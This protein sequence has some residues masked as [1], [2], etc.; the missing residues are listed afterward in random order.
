MKNLLAFIL[1]LAVSSITYA[2]G[3]FSYG[4]APA[5]YTWYED[6]SDEAGAVVLKPDGWFTKVEEKNGTG[7]LFISKEDIEAAGKFQTGMSLNLVHHVK[8][9]TGLSSSKYAIS[10]LTK[11]LEGNEELMS[12]GTPGKGMMTI[13]L[14][15]KNDK[16]GKI[17]HYYLVADDT[18]DTLRIFM[19]ESPTQ[20]W[21]SAWKIGEPMFRNL[22]LIFPK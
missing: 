16:L 9:T 10:F 8:K 17:I 14:R 19:F 1:L 4:S 13:G 20:E 18:R 7:A 21:D 5:G 11:A 2:Q 3:K 22:R 6:A 15:V 12:F